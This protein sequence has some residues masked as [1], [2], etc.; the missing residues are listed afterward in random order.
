VSRG[1]S[2]LRP[3]VSVL[4]AEANQL[5][6]QLI[7]SAFRRA[8]RKVVV[9]GATVDMLA[10]L[11]ALKEQQPDVAIVSSRLITGPLDGFNLVRDITSLKLRTRVVMLLESRER[12]V[13]VDAFR[14][15][16]HGVVFRD[17]P[18][19]TLTKC[20]HA[21]NRGQVWANSE[22]LG[23]LL[24]A[25]AR[26]MPLSS[27]KMNAGD[28]LTRRETDIVRLLVEGM[29]NREISTQLRLSEHTVRNYLFR[30]FDKVGVSTR[31]E[32]VLYCLR[33]AA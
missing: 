25:L 27:P 32:L 4:I 3:C 19:E 30:V 21:V 29:T 5:N 33:H 18:V 8:R 13:V 15:G 26:A 11:S 28:R 31:V 22:N 6:C 1:D 23:F 24:D 7:Q 2:L 14:F 20:I 10:A 16:A 12:E 9:S 17:E